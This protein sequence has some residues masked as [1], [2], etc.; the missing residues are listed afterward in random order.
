MTAKTR[1]IPD[2]VFVNALKM[3]GEQ[4][5]SLLHA[6]IQRVVLRAIQER[7]D[8]EIECIHKG[9]F[10]SSHWIREILPSRIITALRTPNNEDQCMKAAGLLGQYEL[11]GLDKGYP[12][13]FRFKI[14]G[15]TLALELIEPKEDNCVKMTFYEHSKECP[16]PELQKILKEELET[17]LQ[18]GF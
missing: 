18:E 10:K 9:V 4:G 11:L 7:V 16:D 1:V 6:L 8:N 13:E 17:I 14:L 5:T 15:R 12:A 2:E 3:R